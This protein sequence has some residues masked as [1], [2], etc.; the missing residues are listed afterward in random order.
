MMW[1]LVP[2]T[3]LSGMM[4]YVQ[5]RAAYRL[6]MMRD[7][8]LREVNYKGGSLP[9]ATLSRLIDYVLIA[10]GIGAAVVV[11]LAAFQIVTR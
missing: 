9:M 1:A 3:A 6:S 8:E 4:Q 11:A 5:N 7:H 10:T 2:V